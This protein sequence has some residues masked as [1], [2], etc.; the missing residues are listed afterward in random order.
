[1][2]REL[3]G[4]HLQMR[5]TWPAARVR[6]KPDGEGELGPSGGLEQHLSVL[7]SWLVGGLFATQH[8]SGGR[9]LPPGPWPARRM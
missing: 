6:W 3:L 1:M 2:V 7:A 4:F 5:T 9:V 8:L